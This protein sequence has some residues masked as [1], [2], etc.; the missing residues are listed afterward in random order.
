M[1]RE[2][3]MLAL[4]VLIGYYFLSMTFYDL[5][6]PIYELPIIGPIVGVKPFELLRPWS[7][8][9]GGCLVLLVAYTYRRKTR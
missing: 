3:A 5:T 9:V 1:N 6:L 4:A 7:V 2:V 8:F